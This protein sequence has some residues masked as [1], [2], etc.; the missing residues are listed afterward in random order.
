MYS[1]LFTDLVFLDGNP[2]ESRPEP[3]WKADQAFNACLLLDDMHCI[4]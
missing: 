1:M 3:T 4:A 2:Q